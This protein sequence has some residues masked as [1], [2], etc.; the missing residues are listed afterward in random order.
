MRV[1]GGFL[2]ER[3]Q[4]VDALVQSTDLGG[5]VVLAGQLE[6]ELLVALVKE[7]GL[8]VESAKAVD[9]GC[10]SLEFLV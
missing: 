1:L 7:I 4:L 2:Q 10:H 8:K 3:G 6:D 9:L 5:F